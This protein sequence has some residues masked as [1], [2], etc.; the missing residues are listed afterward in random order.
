[1]QFMENFVELV[2]MKETSEDYFVSL[3]GA[4]D[5][6]GVDWEQTES[7]CRWSTANDG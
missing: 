7:D 4:L 2:P 6:I 5:K 1:M 3:V